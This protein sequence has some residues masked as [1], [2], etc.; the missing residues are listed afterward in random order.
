[1]RKDD[2]PCGRGTRDPASTLIGSPHFNETRK[3]VVF[4]YL[5]DGGPQEVWLRVDSQIH[6]ATAL[7]LFWCAWPALIGRLE[8]TDPIDS[9]VMP[10]FSI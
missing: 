7:E 6:A 9:I 5:R 2:A 3:C 1:M 4:H 10:D 8:S